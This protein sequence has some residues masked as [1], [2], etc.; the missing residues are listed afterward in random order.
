MILRPSTVYGPRSREVL[1]EIARAIRAG[2]MVLIGGGRA[3]AG[4]CFVENLVD[5]TLLA[6]HHDDVRGQAFNVTDGLSVTWRQLTDDLAGGLGC[7]PVRWSMPYPLAEG[8]GFSLEHGYRALRTV[9]GLSTRPL[10]SRQAV[11]VMGRDQSF[12][13]RRAGEL[14]GWGPRVDY[15]TG[16]RH[17]LEWLISEDISV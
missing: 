13:N 15:A 17:T 10:L 11:Q 4:L 6:M 14:L 9:T 7:R 12:S 5:A 1:L 2:N 3:I 8:I 16:L